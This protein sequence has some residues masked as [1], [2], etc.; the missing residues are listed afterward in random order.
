MCT[1]ARPCAA[2]S[3][4]VHACSHPVHFCAHSVFPSY[5]PIFHHLQIFAVWVCSLYAVCIFLD[6]ALKYHVSICPVYACCIPSFFAGFR[7]ILR[8]F[9]GT[10]WRTSCRSISVFEDPKAIQS[11]SQASYGQLPGPAYICLILPMCT[12][13][14]PT[15]SEVKH[16]ANHPPGGRKT[17]STSR[18]SIC[19]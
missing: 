9:T 13:S 8:A 15:N 18:I 11:I 2:C 16:A 6:I 4:H 1:T 19:P 10:T 17:G 7:V 3:C 5:S 12:E 14:I